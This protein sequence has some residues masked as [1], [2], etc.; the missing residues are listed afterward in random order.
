MKYD[1]V[2][3]MQFEQEFG[4]KLDDVAKWLAEKLPI[5]DESWVECPECGEE[6]VHVV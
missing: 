5:Q 1:T 4:V 6:F 3:A 2:V